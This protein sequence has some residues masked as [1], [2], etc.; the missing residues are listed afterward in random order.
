M[1]SSKTLKTLSAV[2][3]LYGFA[4]VLTAHESVMHVIGIHG[5][6][7]HLL[8]DFTPVIVLCVLGILVY[9]YLGKFTGWLSRKIAKF[10]ARKTA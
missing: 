4:P 7:I 9:L 3:A 10:S 8:S 6:W 5:N 2:V 1:V